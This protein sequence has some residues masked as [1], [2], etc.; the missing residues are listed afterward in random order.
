MFAKIFALALVIISAEARSVV[1]QNLQ[2]CPDCTPKIDV[3]ASVFEAYKKHRAHVAVI[4]DYG[5]CPTTYSGYTWDVNWGDDDEYKKTQ[6]P[7]GPYQ[8]THIYSKKGKY[9][10]EVNLCTHQD[11]CEDAC[12]TMKKPI[13]VKP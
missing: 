2:S 9:T 10:I 7:M 12:S 3:N 1:V 11:G 6:D 8:A 4:G 5:D 13:V